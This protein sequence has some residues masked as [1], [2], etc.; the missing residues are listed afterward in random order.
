MSNFMRAAKRL[1]GGLLLVVLTVVSGEAAERE[2]PEVPFG[3]NQSD[4]SRRNP[5]GR[6]FLFGS[7]RFGIATRFGW[8]LAGANSEIYDFIQEELTIEDSDFNVPVFQLDFA[9]F[10]KPR[11]A[12]MFRFEWSRARV[13]SEFRDF[14]EQDDSPITQKTELSKTPLTGNIKFYLTPRGREI[15]RYAWVPNAVATYVG[16]G[17]GLIWYK[18]HHFGDFVD[19]E[20]LSIF[21]DSFVSDGWAPTFQVFGGVEV[22]LHRHIYLT[23]EGSYTWADATMSQDF[24]DFDPID[25]RGLKIAGGAEIIF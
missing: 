6:D 10:F 21:T 22:R 25:L 3:E 4:T 8:S 13:D 18:F 2:R 19:F 20:D 11:V 16:G 1:G 23:I 12:V 9:W 7:P 17:G 5:E 15:S 24:V 14:V